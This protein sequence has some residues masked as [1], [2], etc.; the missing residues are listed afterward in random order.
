MKRM[1]LEADQFFE[2]CKADL[3]TLATKGDI[4]SSKKDILD[5]I[6]DQVS[7]S[8]SS[9]VLEIGCFVAD[10]LADLSKRFN[11]S[12]SGVEPSRK[13]VEFAS[14]T[15]NLSIEN[16]S[17]QNSCYFRE[18]TNY[19]SSYDLIIAEDVLSWMPRHTLLLTLG[20]IDH[21][22]KPGGHLILRDFSPSF[23]FAFQNHHIKTDEVFNFKQA[24]GHK[25]FFLNSGMY[26]LLKNTVVNSKNFVL[27]QHGL[28]L[29]FGTY[30]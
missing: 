1:S 30:A 15:F 20:I 24:N 17:F 8:Q 2:R 26:V 11:C 16:C 28:M 5:L 22:L 12:V 4:R 7:L 13:A 3:S 29:P 21:I 6:I 27:P 19:E 9:S 25:S 14:T 10:L 18:F 23:S